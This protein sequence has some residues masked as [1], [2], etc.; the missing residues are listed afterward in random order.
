MKI[1]S[2]KKI[3]FIDLITKKVHEEISLDKHSKAEYQDN[4]RCT[5]TVNK[6]KLVYFM[7]ESESVVPIAT[8]INRLCES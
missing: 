7:T 2:N 4:L 1:Y 6:S 3:E 5:I 8:I